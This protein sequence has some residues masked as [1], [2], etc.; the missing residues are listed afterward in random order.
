MRLV[1]CM[2]IGMV[3]LRASAELKAE[4]AFRF[5]EVEAQ[6]G[7]GVYSL[8]RRFQLDAYSCNFAQFYKLNSLKRNAPLVRG[9]TYQI[10]IMVYTFDGR[11]IRTTIGIEDWDQAV[12]IRDYNRELE[13]SGIRTGPYE[14]NK[15]LWVPFHEVNCPKPDLEIPEP[16]KPVV[17]DP[18]EETEKALNVSL[19]ES[20]PTDLSGNLATSRAKNRTFPIFGE[21][22][23]Y[24]PLVSEK[25]KGK[26]F[27]IVS[28]H[29]GPDPGAIGKRGNYRLCEDEYAY[30]VAL[31]LCRNLIAHGATAY[32]I[33]RD[34]NDGIRSEE[35]LTCDY[36][37]VLWGNVTMKRSQKPRLFQRS[38]IVNTLYATN[39]SK[40]VADANQTLIA[41]HVDSRLK[42]E[43]IDLFFY[44]HRTQ[45][46]GKTL[47][48]ELHRTIESK[49]KQYRKSGEYH[50][51]I[52]SRDLHMLREVDPTAV[53]IELGNIF[54]NRDQQRIIL[55]SNRQYLA[56]WLFEGLIK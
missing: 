55:E 1:A 12:R 45:P 27:Y 25:L 6:A 34:P 11:S 44:Y 17:N 32:M 37:E 35:F 54:H 41:I 20:R 47:A 56:D 39:K 13:A 19:I 10:P 5:H 31:R 16:D 23:A 46:A 7:D 3:F 52:S 40:G 30:D 24:T 38:D 21:K 36:D 9:K 26:V 43:Q 33:T 22:Y 14:K 18:G 29:G 8:L 48:K 51:T 49:Y 15:T 50:G 28:G 53:Y 2:L 42:S 4:E